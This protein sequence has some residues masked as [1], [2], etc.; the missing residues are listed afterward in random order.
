MA[1][2]AGKE[3]RAGCL[4][5]VKIVVA[6]PDPLMEEATEAANL[7]RKGEAIRAEV[8]TVRGAGAG[9]QPMESAAGLGKRTITFPLA[10]LKCERPVFRSMI[11][12]T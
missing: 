6:R 5:R 4:A 7:A 9:M 2:C 3:P 12:M 1:L 10:F 11:S 8:H